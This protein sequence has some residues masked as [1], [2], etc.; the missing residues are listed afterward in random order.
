MRIAF[1]LALAFALLVGLL[2][3]CTGPAGPAG[4]AGPQFVLTSSAFVEKGVIPVKYTGAGTNA[5]PPLSWSGV[6]KGTKSF[7]LAMVDPDVPWG[8]EVPGYGRLPPP[9]TQPGDFFIHWIVSDIPVTVTSLPEG[10]SPK[11]MP[12]GSKE[13]KSS[14]ALL[15]MSAN[16]YGGPAPP[17]GMKAHAYVFTLYALDVE[18]LGLKAEDDYAIFTKA[19]AGHVIATASL[20]GYFGQ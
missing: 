5:S 16:Q 4:P 11:S 19:M 18:T 2:P 14:F 3:A 15:G 10:A 1:C 20:T 13:L 6:P 9:G 17:P 7:A 12:A 8:Q